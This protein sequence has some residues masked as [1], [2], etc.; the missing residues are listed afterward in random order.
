MVLPFKRIFISGGAG[1]IGQEMVRRLATLP[2]DIQVLVGD[3]KPRPADFPTRFQ[4]RQG[5]LS[6]LTEQEIGAFGPDLFIHLAATFERST[7]TYGFWEENF[8]HNVRLSHHLMTVQKD[9]PS[10]RRVVFASSYLIYDPALYNFAEVP[11]QARSLREDDPILPRNLTGMAKLAHEI[12]LRFLQTFRAEQFSTAIPRIYRGY[13]RNGRDITSR[14]VRM[15]LAGEEITVYGAES[16]FDY[17]YA[18]DTAEGLLRLAAAETVTG[19]INLGTGR[20]RRVS[21]VVDVLKQNFPD[22]RAKY[23]ASDIPFEAS[24]ADMTLWSSQIDWLPPTTLETAIPEIIAYEQARVNAPTAKAPGHVLISSVAAKVPLVR[25]VQAAAKRLH[26]DIKVVGG[27]MNHACLGQ[28][29]TDEFWL[30]PATADEH[31]PN[32]IRHC[33][34]HGIGHIIPTRDGELAF[35]SRHRTELAEAGIAVLVSAPEAVNR[36]IDKLEFS[37]FGQENGLPIIPAALGPDALGITTDVHGSAT[38]GFVVKE[39]HGAGSLSLGLN[40][41]EAAALTHAHALQEPI[42]QPFVEG[43]EISV[44]AYVDRRGKVRG[45]V[46]RTRD[47]I[48]HGESQVTTT[49]DAPG[50]VARLIPIV[51]KLGLYGPLV[52]QALLTPDGGLHIIECNCRFGGASTL[53]IAAGVDSFFWFLQEAAGA[54]LNL[55]PFQPAAGPL[56]QVRA[57]AD[58][59]TRVANHQ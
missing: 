59:V 51:E 33:L 8:Q 24:Q 32:I 58:V 17:L 50:L 19:I 10:L 57:A 1:V 49:L 47:V 4:Y 36:C 7:E 31:L 12:E 37:T 48:I 42:F 54:D 13:G 44:D 23:V 21:D 20:A 15:L 16:Y 56:R 40:L 29:F 43:R 46:P 52:L 3:I 11:A 39:R 28:H 9:L 6:Y 27:D 2:A 45:L 14:W 55:F 38:P 25:A 30:M 35:W 5:D 34:D 26:P 22:L 53:G 18:A 41:P